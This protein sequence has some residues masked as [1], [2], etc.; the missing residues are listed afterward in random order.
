MHEMS[1]AVELMRQLESLAAEHEIGRI[2]EISVQAGVMKAIVPDALEMA[3]EALAQGTVAEGAGI[4]L[5]IIPARA[6]CRV[7]GKEFEPGVDSFL[8]SGCNQADVEIVE[9]NDI[10]LR[11]VS[12]DPRQ[13]ADDGED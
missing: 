6:Q 10:V 11:S 8:C 7:C 9:G 13:E 5:E 4:N 12:F 3:F 1:I 2:R